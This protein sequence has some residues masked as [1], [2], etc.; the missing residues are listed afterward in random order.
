M[1]SLKCYLIENEHRKKRHNPA[2]G[3][4][5]RNSAAASGGAVRVLMHV[6]RTVPAESGCNLLL[7]AK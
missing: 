6:Q 4:G 3:G 5:M 7:Y 1:V 2:D